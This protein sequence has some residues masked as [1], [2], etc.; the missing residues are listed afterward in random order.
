MKKTPDEF[1][2]RK[3][4]SILVEAMAYFFVYAPIFTFFYCVIE[5]LKWLFDI[6]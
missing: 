5:F 6:K 4:P 2:P 3:K 1:K